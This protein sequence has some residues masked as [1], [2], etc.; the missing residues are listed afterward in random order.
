MNRW[1]VCMLVVLVAVG[2]ALAG[3]APIKAQSSVTLN[4]DDFVK[5]TG[6]D[7]AAKGG[8]VLTI[9]W[10]VSASPT[11]D[12]TVMRGFKDE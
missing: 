6:Y 11:I 5:I 3:E 2:S 1:T 9:P 12:S 10:T 7:P 4:W 8:Q